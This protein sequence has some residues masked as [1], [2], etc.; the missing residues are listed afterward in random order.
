VPDYGQKLIKLQNSMS[1]EQKIQLG[2]DLL[3]K[4]FNALAERFDTG[5]QK[6]K[7]QK[8][9]AMGKKDQLGDDLLKEEHV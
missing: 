4:A 2:D 5:D 8:V 3:L 1:E 6:I 9:N 7:N